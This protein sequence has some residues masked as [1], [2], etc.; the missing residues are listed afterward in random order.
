MLDQLLKN[1][2]DAFGDNDNEKASEFIEQAKAIAVTYTDR[3][4][5]HNV[6]VYCRLA[7]GSYTGG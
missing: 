3:E 7:K 5:V 1:A 6:A 2:M 4:R